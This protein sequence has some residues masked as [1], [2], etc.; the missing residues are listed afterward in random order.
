MNK[1]WTTT[2]QEDPD[3]P[4]QCIIVFPEELMAEVGWVEGDLIVWDMMPD[5]TCTLKKKAAD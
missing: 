3:D 5:G 2:V 4:E 1:V